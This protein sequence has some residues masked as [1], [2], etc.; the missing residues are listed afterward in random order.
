MV[1]FYWGEEQKALFQRMVWVWSLIL[2][3]FMALGATTFLVLTRH[4]HPS[5]IVEPS[6]TVSVSTS[7]GSGGGSDPPTVI[8]L[9]GVPQL[10]SS[11]EDPDETFG[12]RIWAHED[13]FLAITSKQNLYLYLTNDKGSV[14]YDRSFAA[15]DLLTSDEA[16]FFGVD[17][18]A[19]IVNGCF[20]PSIGQYPY[21]FVT[22]GHELDGYRIG[23]LVVGLVYDGTVWSAHV[24]EG[25]P[26]RFPTLPDPI[27]WTGGA[28]GA[29][30]Q[31]VKSVI[32]HTATED[33]L[34]VYINAT[35]VSPD[36]PGG[37]V[38]W[39]SMDHDNLYPTITFLLQM[40]D[41]RLA[42][43][44]SVNPQN[45]TAPTTTLQYLRSFGANFDVSCDTN[46]TAVLLISNPGVEDSTYSNSTQSAYFSTP[47][48][49]GYVQA[50]QR[51]EALWSQVKDARFTATD[52]G[53]GTSLVLLDPNTALV[54]TRHL[55][56][57]YFITDL[58]PPVH[59]TTDLT[60]MQSV[61]PGDS[62]FSTQ[63]VS[64]GSEWV[65]SV[66]APMLGQP[67]IA[68]FSWVYDPDKVTTT[69]N[70]VQKFGLSVF[71][72]GGSKVVGYG[73]TLATWLSPSGRVVFLA[74]NEPENK[75]V[76]VYFR[77]A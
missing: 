72:P 76:A 28:S 59:Q 21:L 60:N 13:G 70:L 74:V 19:V 36:Q 20:A 68:V 62:L 37:S 7:G 3:V 61:D 5:T 40:T 23:R 67:C 16:A 63:F 30:G 71:V 8:T 43:I 44:Y 42:K 29:V 57:F 17:R 46:A 58:Q 52:P 27:Q 33:Q 65:L 22:I 10:L 49:N 35:N 6:V 53:F 66:G 11:P 56:T 31:V 26:I 69:L 45:V 39:F 38:Y 41:D 2:L 64:L 25:V 34:H 18:P 73:Q 32:D 77:N 54:T 55:S 75:R 15:L 24:A 4:H 12:E 47:S 48:P 14:E 51:V 50:Y 1:F 9:F